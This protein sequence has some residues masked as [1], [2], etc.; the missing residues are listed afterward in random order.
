M[1]ALELGCNVIDTSS[2]YSDGGSEH[3]IGDV[4]HELTDHLHVLQR[5]VSALVSLDWTHRLIRKLLS[6]PKSVMCR[7]QISAGHVIK[8]HKANR[9]PKW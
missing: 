9:F 5:D 3:V 4:I 6:F 1:R 8:S 2:N 7:I